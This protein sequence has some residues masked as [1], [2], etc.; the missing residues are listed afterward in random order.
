MD[1]AEAMRATVGAA[2]TPHRPATGDDTRTT[3]SVFTQYATWNG[4]RQRTVIAICEDRE[5]GRKHNRTGRAISHA[6]T[7]TRHLQPVVIGHRHP[8]VAT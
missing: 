6:G 2:G 7:A 1:S 4:W 8:R 5:G 3:L